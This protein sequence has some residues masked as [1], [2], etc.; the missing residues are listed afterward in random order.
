MVLEV[1]LSK[2][3]LVFQ[4]KEY[5]LNDHIHVELFLLPFHQI[6]EY[7]FSNIHHSTLILLQH[8]FLR[9]QKSLAQKDTKAEGLIDSFVGVP[10]DK[11]TLVVLS[12]LYLSKM[13]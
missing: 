12:F 2:V 8:F 5:L 13:I 4:H 3:G 11:E 10:D 9:S 1:P 7:A 6:S